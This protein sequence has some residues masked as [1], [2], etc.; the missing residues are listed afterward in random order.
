MG[1]GGL[2]LQLR[3]RPAYLEIGGVRQECVQT[4]CWPRPRDAGPRGPRLAGSVALEAWEIEFPTEGKKAAGIQ[5]LRLLGKG[6]TVVHRRLRRQL[7]QFQFLAVLCK[8][9]PAGLLPCK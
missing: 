2:S 7:L 1:R 5:C 8:S 3:C 6:E 9:Q 4:L